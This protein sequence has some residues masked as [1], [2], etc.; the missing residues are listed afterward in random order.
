MGAAAHTHSSRSASPHCPCYYWHC[1]CPCA[2]LS[3]DGSL[4]GCVLW[5]D[6]AGNGAVDA[7]D[8]QTLIANGALDLAATTE[9]M[10]PAYIIP[11]PSTDFGK[12]FSAADT[13]QDLATG[14]T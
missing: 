3:Y 12:A 1:R 13:C 6:A 7:S 14:M 9:Q 2:G 10:G 5:F 11:A 4:S 8:A